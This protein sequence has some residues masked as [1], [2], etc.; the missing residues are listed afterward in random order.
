[1]SLL[2]G[3]IGGAL[4][5]LGSSSQSRSAE[6]AAQTSANAQLEAARIAAEEARF[7]PVGITTRFG[8]SQF[9]VDD[10]GRVTSAG[11]NIS[12]ELAAI[13]DRLLSQAGGQGLGLSEQALGATQGLFN[14]GQQ[15]LATSPEQAAADY[16]ARQQAA[17][18]P[19]RE[20]A[21]SDIRQNLFNTGRG[22]LA[23][24]QGGDMG[25]ANP[26][27]QAYY[28]ALAQQDLNLAAQAQQ[29]GRAAT[30]FGAGLFGEGAKVAQSGLSPLQSQIGVA[31]ELEKLGQAPLD[32]GAALGG[33]NVNT[34]GANALLQG[35]VNAANIMQQATSGS[36]TGAFLSGL[37]NN[38][39]FT[40]GVGNWLGGLMSPAPAS[41]SQ[42]TLSTGVGGPGLRAPSTGFW[43]I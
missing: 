21:L 22:G 34:T 31:S 11:Y 29:E 6:R 23:V 33:R 41:P 2:G 18:A 20:R 13:Q 36:S 26:E 8:T 9:G 15:Y 4:G 16:M 27:L 25:A 17:L 1:M 37:A 10:Q 28:N 43:G 35:G 42:Y 5:L 7:R 40:Q 32:I 39:Q 12:P 3:L 19:S 38:Q 24:A 30:Q 14:L